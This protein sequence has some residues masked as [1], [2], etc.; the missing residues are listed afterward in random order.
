METD[1]RIPLLGFTKCEDARDALVLKEGLKELDL[2]LP[3]GCSSMRRRLQLQKLYPGINVVPVRGNLQTR[4]RKLDEGEY[5]AL[6]LAAAGLK[7]LG[8]EKR[9]HKIFSAEEMI[10]AAGQGVI[11]V[12]GRKGEDY[13][14][15]DGIL[16]NE[17][18]I[19]AEAERAFVRA[20]NGGCSSPIAAHAQIKNDEIIL[21]GLYGP[22]D[23]ISTEARIICRE[24]GKIKE[25]RIIGEKLAYQMK[26]KAG[27]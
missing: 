5:G 4:F 14:Y 13:S 3:V 20:L 9:I 12:Q 21:S 19:K 11:A 24:R 2:S 22:E 7:R 26:E 1:E 15:L 16:D 10:P 23:N 25:A 8:L 17:S 6:V 18:G 27:E